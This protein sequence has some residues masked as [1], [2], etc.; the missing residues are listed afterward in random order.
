ML[1]Q[2]LGISEVSGLLGVDDLSVELLVY[3]FVLDVRLKK[4]IVD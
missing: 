2:Y 3:V 4:I 1:L